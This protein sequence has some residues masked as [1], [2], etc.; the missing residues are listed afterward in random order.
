[1]KNI[2]LILLHLS[3]SLAVLGC[4]FYLYGIMP[5]Q[6][7]QPNLEKFLVFLV[8]FA[9][10][11]GFGYFGFRRELP[12]PTLWVEFGVLA[13]ILI[14]LFYSYGGKWVPNGFIPPV[15][16]YGFMVVDATKML[17]VDHENPYS[18]QTISPIRDILGPDHRGY[19]YGPLTMIGYLP[20]LY[21][22]YSGYKYAGVFFL[23]VCA[24]LLAF[25][26]IE[27]GEPLS[28]RVANI[29]FVETAFF[30]PERMWIELFSRGAHDFM[31]VAF[32]LAALLALKKDSYFLVGLLAGLSFS[33]KFSPAL[34]LLPFL[35]I[36]QKKMWIGLAAGMLPQ[37]PFLIWDF[38]GYV[39]NVFLVR[40][41]MP[42]DQSSLRYYLRPEHYWWLPASLLI[43]M[44]LS[45]YQ[46][47]RR[48]L[49]FRTVLV[50]FTL[51]LIVGE[52]TFKQVHLNH[53]VW[54]FPL[55]AL[56]FTYDRERLFGFVSA[57]LNGAWFSRVAVPNR[58]I[59]E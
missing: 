34:F 5:D 50:G 48:V 17:W 38:T 57:P 28:V 51:L 30:L 24:V 12:R 47:F 53:L 11:A 27:P 42:S 21:W 41:I 54:F 37:V 1:M 14:S 45:V 4:M 33:T 29:A 23:L 13:V 16:D 49:G 40:V 20:S 46:N 22:P 31:P 10:I 2:A 8:F 43:A 9:A 36:R 59:H 3:C 39:N 58:E 35:P 56:I 18:S 26:V 44:V 6:D 55:F 19:Y 15:A 7:W 52:V 32:I 25:L